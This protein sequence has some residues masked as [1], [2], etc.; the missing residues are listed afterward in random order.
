MNLSVDVEQNASLTY[1]LKKYIAKGNTY[2]YYN[3]RAFKN[4]G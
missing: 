3:Y 4:E 2:F 1:C